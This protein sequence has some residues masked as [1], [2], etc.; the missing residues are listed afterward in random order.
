MDEFDRAELRAE[1]RRE[2]Q[3]RYR[4]LVEN[5]YGGDPIWQGEPVCPAVTHTLHLPK[6]P[7]KRTNEIGIPVY[8]DGQVIELTVKA[9]LND[10]NAGQ[11]TRRGFID[12]FKA[13]LVTKF[14]R[15]EIT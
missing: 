12:L 8:V 1:K 4:P 9:N 5:P 7:A 3:Q 11:R 2:K 15:V 6:A 10:I 13:A 14:G